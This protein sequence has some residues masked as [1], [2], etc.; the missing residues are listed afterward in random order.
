MNVDKTADYLNNLEKWEL[1]WR[2]KERLKESGF[3]GLLRLTTFPVTHDLQLLSALV[4]SYDDVNR[5]FIVNNHKLV[6]GLEDILHLIG[7]PIDG[8]PVTGIDPK[9]QQLSQKYLGCC[10]P[11]CRFAGSASF[12]WL[13]QMFERV[14]ENIDINSPEIEPYVRAFLLY[15]I[16]SIVV[17][18]R[19]GNSV[20]LMYLS[21]MEKLEDIKEYAWGAA[22]LAHLHVSLGS[23]KQVYSL[24]SKNILMGHSY[25]LMVN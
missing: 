12:V 4:E 22:M 25:A 24:G 2:V 9:N 23:F 21:L 14:P 17:P 20:P 18:D 1:D 11:E 8:K 16:G 7:L 6:Y 10:N 5:C 3:D 13:K 19:S 15:L